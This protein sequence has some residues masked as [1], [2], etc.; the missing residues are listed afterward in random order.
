[1]ISWYNFLVF[2]MVIFHLYLTD[3]LFEMFLWLCSST[4]PT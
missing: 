1:M 2:G 3:F 4:E